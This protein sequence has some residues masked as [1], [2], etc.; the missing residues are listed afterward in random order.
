MML[1]G[2]CSGASGLHS[3]M[4]AMTSSV[5]TTLLANFSPPWTTRWPTASISFMEATTPFCGST[6][7]FSTVWMASLW[8]GMAT[9]TASCFSLP[10][11]WGL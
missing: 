1:A 7:A 5:M 4:A 2:L 11:S 10:G 8:V 9:S 3:S 6:S